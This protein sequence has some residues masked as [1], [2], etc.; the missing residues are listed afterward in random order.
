MIMMM[1]TMMT[2]IIIIIIRLVFRNKHMG[3]MSARP[4]T[5]SVGLRWRVELGEDKGSIN[6]SLTLR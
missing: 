5:A 3:F 2:I 6:Q 4:T 1:M